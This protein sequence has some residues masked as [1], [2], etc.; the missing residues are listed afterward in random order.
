MR[1][2][3]SAASTA[4]SN[5][6]FPADRCLFCNKETIAVKRVKYSLVTCRTEIAEASIKS[7]ALEK[8]D[9]EILR[10]VRDQDLIAREARYHN[11]CRREYTR[12]RTRHTTHKDSESA[13]SLS[14]HNDAL[15]YIFNYIQEHI[16]VEG[17]VERLSMLR[18]RYLKFL[19]EKHPRFYNESYKTYKLKDKLC[20]HFGNKLSFWQPRKKAELVYAAD[21]EGE[22]VEAAFELAASDERRLIETAMIIR[23]VIKESR[24]ESEPMPWP[25]SAAW[26]LSG[27]RRPPD[28]LLTFLIYII[29][30]KPVKHASGRSQRYGLSFAEDLCYAVTN[31]DWVMPKH[32]TLPMTVRHLTG[33]AEVITI[34][35]RYGHGQSYT[36]T[37]ELET[38]MCNSVTSSDS[39]LPRS[40]SRDNNAVLHLCYD[41]FDLDEETPSGSGTTH[42]THGIVI[43]EVRN[44]GTPLVLT[45]MGT[46]PKSRERSVTPVEVEIR[47]CYAK[48]KVDPKLDIQTSTVV[49]NFETSEFEDFEWLICREIG[50][51]ME[52]QKVP[53]WAGWLSQTSAEKECNI[54]TVEYMAPLSESINENS[55]VQYI[56]EQ[57]LAA[58][59]EVGQEYAIVTFDLAVAKKA[60]ALVWQYS[61]QFNK[62]I[63]R[64]GVFHT[65]CSLFGTLG[66]MMKGS[67]LAEIIIESGICASGSLDRVMNGKHFNRALRVHK[68]MFEALER[69]L[70]TRFAESHPRNELLSKETYDMLTDLIDDPCKE[71]VSKVEDSEFRNYFEKYHAFILE[72]LNGIHGKTAQFWMRYMDI[73]QKI[74]TLI[75]ATKENNLQLHIAALYALCPMFFAYDHCNYARYVPVYLMTLMNLPKTHPGCKELLEKNG[76]SVSRSSVPRSRNA[77]DITIEQTINRHAKSQGGVIGFS[78]NYAAYNRW[79]IT[80]HLRAQYVEASLQR[81]DMSYDEAS[82]HKDLG[83]SQIQ[84]SERD[85][86]R[87]LEAIAGFTNPFSSDVNPDELYC[88]SSGVPAKSEV[89]NDLLQ[90]PV[91]GQKSMEDFIKLRLVERSVGFH[92]PIKRNKLKTFAASEV[93]KKLTSSQNKISQIRAERNVF[94]QLVLLSLEHDVDLELTLS[95][96]LGPVP[97]PLATADGMPVKTD[98][99]RLLHNLESSIEPT[100]DRPSDAVH[101]ID[102]NA[103]L[104]SL[105]PIPDTFE[106]LAEHVFNRLPKS[107]RVDFT[108]DTYKPQSIKS[109]ERARRG[110]APTFLLSGARTKTPHEW[111]SFMS[112]DKNKTQLI[113]LLLEQ[114][115]TDKYAAKL[116]DRN[117][118][119]VIGEKVYRL[120]SEDGTAV[121]AYPEESLFS[122]QEEADTRI[123]LHC[124]N[125]SNSLPQTCCIIIRSPDTDVLV[126]LAKYCKDIKNK[127]LFDTGM[128]NKRRLLNVNDIHKNKG[129]DICS[130]LPALHCFT[131]CDTTSAFV[132]RGKIAPLKLVE[133]NPQPVH[134]Y[135]K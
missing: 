76:F 120:T 32:L 68:L 117:I 119:Y 122:S 108:T 112:N 21:I 93:T 106:E 89:A 126:L 46:A 10:K 42:S 67:G 115:K 33:S 30:G 54:S 16:L 45:E 127:I 35:N 66:K 13:Q 44:P 14:A 97:W 61:D 2:R 100:T 125:V 92:E 74:L 49:Y 88:L 53:S 86:K 41:N 25:P 102:G 135:S 77:V 123:I 17:K 113:N 20:K 6:L 90:A 22:A 12:S 70:L 96:P 104:Q 91:I 50:D 121:S 7:A 114:W 85:V 5:V 57:A 59:R 72:V 38:A 26:L 19:L 134:P 81:T 4:S 9:E 31:G 94:G 24:L 64:M 1:R 34:L 27:E 99:S 37:L 23:R 133:R 28:I 87:V 29:I 80:R 8:G 84:N 98:K 65:I 130:V 111:K 118:Y 110:M 71:N 131:G 36:R 40:I 78:R 95:F 52:T 62:V 132:H 116:V 39:V 18:E 101:I 69:L 75:R 73:I 43:Q 79:C 51:S 63:V 107:K 129:E 58:S 103:M 83:V 82:V 11:C 128:G 56:L 15:Q 124:L 55:T 47:P 109:Y 48:P 105:K 60:Y 3:S